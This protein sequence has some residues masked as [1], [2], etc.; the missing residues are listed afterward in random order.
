MQYCDNL[1]ELLKAQCII[2]GKSKFGVEIPDKVEETA[3]LDEN[4]G[5]SLWKNS[6]NKNMNYSYLTLKLLDKHGKISVGY[7]K[8]TCHLVFDL[9]LDKTRKSRYLA[10]CHLADIPTYMTYSSVMY[11]DAV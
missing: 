7:T 5:N 2:K 8:I 1:I 11:H 3:I 10:G 6:T 4:N 9:N